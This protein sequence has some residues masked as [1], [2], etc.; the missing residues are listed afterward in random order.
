MLDMQSVLLEQHVS[1]AML[2]IQNV[3][4]LAHLHGPVK[5]MSLD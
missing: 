4:H 5:Q 3:V 2:T 1:E